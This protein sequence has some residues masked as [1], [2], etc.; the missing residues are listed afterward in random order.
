[1]C[2]LRFALREGIGLRVFYLRGE[3]IMKK[4]TIIG[5]TTAFLFFL[6]VLAFGDSVEAA[7]YTPVNLNGN[8]YYISDTGV[9]FKNGWAQIGDGI[10][11]F[12]PDGAMVRNTVIDG[13]TIGPDGRTVIP[14]RPQVT[15]TQP[16]I[17]ANSA[18]A[19]YCTN[20]INSVTTPSMTQDQ[21]LAACY[22]Y[23]VRSYRYN[24]TYETPAGNWTGQFALEL[25]S[26]GYGNCYRYASG[27]A[28]LA[29]ALG[30]DVKV[31]TGKVRGSRG[32]MAPHGWVE[33][34]YN[35]AWYVCDPELQ[36]AKGRDLY[37]KTYE[38]YPVKPLNK[39]FEWGV[40]F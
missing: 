12:G 37:M 9:P 6:G 23:I 2:L 1:M 24:R 4:K 35:G 25:F 36:M 21:K 19:Q 28:Y 31:I 3:G 14:A 26:N 34:F 22:M 7:V 18:L 29:K 5:L 13:F 8:I 40:V 27:F 38:T 39:E 17:N 20:I 11:Y 33:I 10:F 30:Y 15:E 16:Q 32:G